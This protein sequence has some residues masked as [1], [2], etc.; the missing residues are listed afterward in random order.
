MLKWNDSFSVNHTGIDGQHQE[1]ID[2][3]NNLVQYIS[4]KDNEFNN[5][6]DLVSKLDKYVDYHFKY[7]ESLMEL[8]SYPEKADHLFQHN[9]LRNKLTELNIFNVDNTNDFYKSLLEEL[10]DWLTKH[11]MM[12][13]KK[14][15][16]FLKDLKN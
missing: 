15:G 11:I 3:I 10:I 7:E 14:L 4:E 6:L 1:L 13:D 5:L 9:S 2:I 16:Q 12:T 8:Y